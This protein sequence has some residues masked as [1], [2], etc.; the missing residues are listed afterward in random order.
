V[1]LHFGRFAPWG[2]LQSIVVSP[3]VMVTVVLGFFTLIAQ[4]AVPPVGAGL[5]FLLREATDLLL[6]AVERL[7]S[8][9]GTLVEVQSPPAGLVLATYALALL[10][11]WLL[12]WRRVAAKT[13]FA[14]SAAGAIPCLWIGWLIW[15]TTS[16]ARDCAIHV[17]S[18]GSGTA[19][20]VTTPD[21]HELLYDVGT[22]HN[23]DAGETVVRA[24]RALGV[25][26]LDGLVLSHANFDHYSGAATLL[27][28]VPTGRLLFNPYFEASATEN[29]TVRR[30][31]DSLPT[32]SP[33]RSTLH[34]GDRFTL[35]E[36]SIEVLWPPDGLDGDWSPNNRSL[37]LRISA[38][39]RSVMLPGDIEREAIR[40]L[41]DRHEIG[42]IDLF[43]DVLI[44]PHHGS[45]V[46]GDTAAFYEAVSPLIVVNST[47]RERPKL[48]T[49]V[50]ETLGQSTRLISTRT[51]G[52]ISVR[53]APTGELNV[54]TPFAPGRQ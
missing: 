42:R 25:R 37:V 50:G 22:M 46:P 13:L 45:V 7:S 3:L 19:V 1:L 21:E 6:W 27:Q 20:L 18:V 30:L 9:P 31:F 48:A 33:P 29:P 35:G 32:K 28:G 40:Q 53:I 23:F 11:L 12:L 39:E 43:S 10:L 34:A 5:G 54:E 52:A 16:T 47:S 8:L 51:A 38:N 14:V 49:L 26:R 2:A 15:P 17:L 36:A 4:M 41:L 44:A 24:A